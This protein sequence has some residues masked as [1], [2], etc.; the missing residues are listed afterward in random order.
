MALT[1]TSI[2]NA[3][4]VDKPLKLFDGGGLYLLVNPNGLRWGRFKYRNLG[5]A[6]LLSFGTYPDISLNSCCRRPARM[7][8]GSRSS[9]GSRGCRVGNAFYSVVL[10]HRPVA[11]VAPGHGAR[12]YRQ[13]R[14]LTFIDLTDIFNLSL[15]PISVQT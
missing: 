11:S 7:L 8:F 3:R 9:K 12:W 15:I 1:A 5:K 14:Y 13:K 10:N 4:A 6:E 2:K